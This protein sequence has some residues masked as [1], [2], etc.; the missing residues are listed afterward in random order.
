LTGI[1]VPSVRRAPWR[2]PTRRRREQAAADAR[3]LSLLSAGTGVPLGLVEHNAALL[4][5][6]VEDLCWRLAV[7]DLHRRRPCRGDGVAQNAWHVEQAR[8]EARRLRLV[9]LTAEAVSAL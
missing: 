7:D 3:N 1:V 6:A 8:L 5:L 4:H 9:Q 2:L